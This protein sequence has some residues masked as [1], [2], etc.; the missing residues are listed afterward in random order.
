MTENNYFSYNIPGSS[1]YY[2]LIHSD[3]PKPIQQKILHYR[4]VYEKLKLIKPAAIS[5]WQTELQKTPELL[6][7][8]DQ[9]ISDAQ[10][11]LYQTDLEL[12]LFYKN[13]AGLS[14]K[15]IGQY[16]YN[17]SDT[18]ILNH[19]ENMGI[20]IEKIN[21][22]NHIQKNLTQSSK[23]YFSGEKLLQHHLNLYEFSKQK[24]NPNLLNLFKNESQEIM[25]YYTPLKLSPLKPTL[26]LANI[27]KALLTEIQR[28][29]FPV[30]THQIALTP[31]RKYWIAIR[32]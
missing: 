26:V 2:S 22:F 24:L 13:T 10:I 12:H 30:F 1:I 16:C 3:Y 14:E 29:G 9:F 4:A 17:I 11:N 25:A 8:L 28:A 6:P 27:Q 18:E 21:Y 19:L 7:I 31:L 23:L 5:W 32:S 20:F 15:I